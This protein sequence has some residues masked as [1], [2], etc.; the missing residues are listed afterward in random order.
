MPATRPYPYPYFTATCIP[1]IPSGASLDAIS[2]GGEQ[3]FRG[4]G[5]GPLLPGTS[6]VPPPDD[7]RADESGLPNAMASAQC[8][9][10]VMTPWRW[11][12]WWWY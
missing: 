11:W 5:V 9:D 1:F 10:G 6:H 12:W 4:H 2:I 8:K 3:I 7:Y